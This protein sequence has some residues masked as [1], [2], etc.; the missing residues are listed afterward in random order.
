[1]SRREALHVGRRND[2]DAWFD[3]TSDR[4]Y[5]TYRALRDVALPVARTHAHD[6]R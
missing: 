6:A 5:N 2:F 3:A 1:M 4:L